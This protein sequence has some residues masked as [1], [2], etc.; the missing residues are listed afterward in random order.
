MRI[1]IYLNCCWNVNLHYKKKHVVF[2]LF[3]ITTCIISIINYIHRCSTCKL[4]IGIR[5]HIGFTFYFI[6]KKGKKP[7]EI[8][9]VMINF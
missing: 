6:L 8:S 2:D 1:Y 4:G 5:L 9:Y 7:V 3:R